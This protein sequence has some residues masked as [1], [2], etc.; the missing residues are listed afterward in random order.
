MRRIK[1]PA[2]NSN[3]SQPGAPEHLAIDQILVPAR[4]REISSEGVEALAKSIS[5]IG[6]LTPITITYLANSAD[7]CSIL[8][9]TLV[10]GAHRL[11]AAK[12][13]GWEKI[14]CL[15]M[16]SEGIATQL[17][18]IAENLHR[19][20]LTKKQRDEHIRRYAEIL[21]APEAQCGQNVSFE[22]QRLDGKG[23]RPKGT[24]AKIAE[25]VGLSTKTIQRA[26]KPGEVEPDPQ[27]TN[28]GEPNA[29]AGKSRLIKAWNKASGED[30][31]WFLDWIDDEERRAHSDRAAE[32]EGAHINTV[33]CSSAEG[34]DQ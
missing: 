1:S 24:A 20:D 12:A 16:E 8:S 9:P 3:S 10:A 31:R 11:E 25:D 28:K 17:W 2:T 5:E 13:L 23:H 14:P 22:S 19:R 34:V 18:E 27:N 32:L 4:R 6:L 15:I 29:E 26:L 33:E 30:R 7:N 21:S